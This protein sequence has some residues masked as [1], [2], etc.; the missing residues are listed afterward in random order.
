GLNR[1][2]LAEGLEFAHAQG[3]NRST[4]LEVLQAGPAASQVMDTKGEKM[5]R[6]DFAP[7]ARLSQHLKDVRLIQA[8]GDLCGARLTLTDHHEQLLSAL[9]ARGLGQLDNSAVIEA[10]RT[11][12]P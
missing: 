3:L 4:A 7:Q 8:E 5:I 6:S 11:A 12:N 2:V 9:E 10:F 1:A